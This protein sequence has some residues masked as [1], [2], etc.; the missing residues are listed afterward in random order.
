MKK[1]LGFLATA[2]LFLFVT[3]PVFAKPVNKPEAPAEKTTG[4]V[5]YD[6]YGLYRHA[7]FN[8]QE[9]STNCDATWTWDVAG[10]WNFD[11]VS[12]VFPGTYPKTMTIT[13]DS[14]G[15]IT[16]SGNNVPAGLTWSVSGSVTDSTVNFALAY[17]APMSGYVATL[18]GSLDSLGHMSG[19]W[20]D[21]WYSDTGTWTTTSGDALKVYSYAGCEGKGNFHYSDVAGNWYYAD[22]KYVNVEGEDAWFGALVTDASE[23]SWVG[24]WVFVK[25]HDGG[26]PATGVDQVWGSF[27]NETIAQNGVATM[28]TPGDG[29]FTVTEGNLQVHTY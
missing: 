22:V 1:L 20:S 10:T 23:T 9:T 11:V 5:G 14:S 15:N 4:G 26:E 16:G 8:A 17:N 18:T 29:P 3:F 6:A 7:E 27:V 25:T 28:G 21:N 24:N 12:T 19:T 13:Q 2:S